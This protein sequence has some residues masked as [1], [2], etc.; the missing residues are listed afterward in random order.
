L[1]QGT[2]Q[3]VI[4]NVVSML[5]RIRAA[6]KSGA[7]FP[8]NVREI[9]NFNLGDP[10]VPFLDFIQHEEQ[11]MLQTGLAQFMG[12]GQGFN[13]GT[14]ALSADASSFFLIAM[15]AIGDWFC[16]YM[17]KY[18]IPQW[19]DINY[20]IR[21]I[22]D[23]VNLAPGVS[24]Y[25]KLRHKPI[26]VRSHKQLADLLI[27]L[28]EKGL[29]DREDEVGDY[30]RDVFGLPKSTNLPIVYPTPVGRPGTIQTGNQPNDLPPSQQVADAPVD[31]NQ[32]GAK[33][34]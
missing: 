16:D 24:L 1:E 26:E 14:F 15:N 7:A 33:A 3:K 5:Q 25:P 19:V 21:M 18:V 34:A 22:D 29:P 28:Y 31:A 2:S 4:D 9:G 8:Y 30:I 20:G 17:N 32:H 12:L 11:T 27:A 23:I 13:Q 6:D 10:G